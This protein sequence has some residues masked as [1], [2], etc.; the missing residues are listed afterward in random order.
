M[1][2]NLNGWEQTSPSLV[3]G[4][5]FG[6]LVLHPIAMLFRCTGGNGWVGRLGAAFLSSFDNG[7]GSMV[8]LFAAL[9]ACLAVLSHVTRPRA[10][11]DALVGQRPLQ[12]LCMFCKDMPERGADGTDHWLPLEQVLHRSQSM[13][14]THGVCPQCKAW[15]LDPQLAALRAERGRT[16]GETAYSERA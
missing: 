11:G 5:V 4:V 9:G 12:R 14:F 1:R 10:D 2:M 6:I 16:G 15:F 7:M 13:E 3:L 8:L